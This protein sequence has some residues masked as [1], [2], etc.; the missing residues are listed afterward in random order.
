MNVTMSDEELMVG[1][2]RGG[3]RR[4]TRRLGTRK[5]LADHPCF[6]GRADR[7]ELIESDGVVLVRGQVPS[8]YLKRVLQE[9]LQKAAASR[10]IVDRV[11][12]VCSNGLSSV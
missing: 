7:F 2:W 10:I 4:E 1:G 6:H 5:M 3:A 12:V 9:V 11:D 8:F